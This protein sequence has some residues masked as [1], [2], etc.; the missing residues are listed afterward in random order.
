MKVVELFAGVGGFRIGL[1]KSS[2]KFFNTIWA[3]QW[4]PSKKNQSAFNCYVDN[5][6]NKANCINFD[7]AEVKYDVPDHDL[8]CGGFPCQ[9]YSVASGNKAA[10]IV[11]KKGVLW[12]EIRDIIQTKKPKLVLL[13]NVDRLIKMPVKQRGR[14]FGIILKCFRDLG[15][16]VEWR[17]VNAADY[18][19]PQ[20][21]K[22]IF[23]VAYRTDLDFYKENISQDDC[24]NYL[25]F[26]TVLNNAFQSVS[27]GKVYSTSLSD[28]GDIYEVSDKFS[29]DYFQN[30]GILI[31]DT[32]YTQRVKAVYKGKQLILRDI[33]ESDVDNKYYLDDEKVEKFKYFKSSKKILRF[34]PNGDEYYYSEGAMSFP[35][36][37]DLPARTMLTTESNVSRT[38]HIILDPQTNKYRTLTPVEAERING[39]PDNWTIKANT[40]KFRYFLMGNALVVGLIELIG[41]SIK[42][43]FKN[44]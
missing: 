8:L 9:D 38:S 37:L 18:G 1:E 42:K 24:E 16:C 29:F 30:S 26:N 21:R 33:L 36:N 12:W 34:K 44:S 41:D 13:E 32:I 35:D 11:G 2:P 14:D 15:Y 22:R 10:G 3:N 17:V 20:K 7:I 31:N 43:I 23:I 25:N 28:Y 27:E 4:E 6:K 39:F 19:F 40:E 5:F